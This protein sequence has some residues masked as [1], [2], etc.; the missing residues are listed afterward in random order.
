[1]NPVKKLKD[2]LNAHPKH[3]ETVENYVGLS[4]PDILGRGSEL[5]EVINNCLDDLNPLTLDE[6]FIRDTRD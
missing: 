4:L 1:M 2:F 3:R 5:S 6:A